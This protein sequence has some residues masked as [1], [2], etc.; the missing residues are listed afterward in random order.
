MVQ[1]TDRMK[2]QH[3]TENL[4]VKFDFPR[5]KQHILRFLLY[6]VEIK[7]IV[8]KT[9]RIIIHSIFIDF[10]NYFKTIMHMFVRSSF[11]H[12]IDK[13]SIFLTCIWFQSI[14]RTPRLKSQRMAIDIW[15]S[16]ATRLAKQRSV[17]V[18]CIGVARPI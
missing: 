12:L 6:K 3:W 16:M 4:V 8:F 17:I 5:R 13:I 18:R 11:S 15:A 2:H 10:L 9:I 1:R 14:Q 7:A